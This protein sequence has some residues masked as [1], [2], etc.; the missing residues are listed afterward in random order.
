[1]EILNWNIDQ[2]ERWFLML[3]RIS[4]MLMVF[5]LYG[6]SSFPTMARL[7]LAFFL[8][9][10]LLPVYGPSAAITAGPG[11]L[12][13]FGIVI[14]EVLVGLAIGFSAQLLFVGVQFAGH[15][16]GHTMGFAMM[17]VI[18]PQSETNIPLIGQLLQ[19]LALLIFILMNGHHFLLLALDESFIQI[20]VGTGLLAGRGIEGI[21]RLSSDI[22][23]V[24]VKIGAP[25]LVAVLVTEAGLGVIART[26]SQINVW[27]IG[28]PLKIGIGLIT[29]AFSLPM[30]VYV[31]GKLYADWQ[32]SLIDFI[33]AMATG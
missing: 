21:A 27:L 18:D 32:G 30:I 16:I 31:F 6:Y 25:V 22:F 11:V 19:L 5:P 24:G 26:V 12:Y 8:A 14:R 4:S 33:R 1:M 2:L 3:F 10:L 20:P 28:F 23:V 29:M 17:N 9:S 15:V 13:F 7:V